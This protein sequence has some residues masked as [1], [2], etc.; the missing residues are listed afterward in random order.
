MISLTA[1]TFSSVWTDSVAKPE[2]PV[3]YGVSVDDFF[4]VIENHGVLVYR[5]KG[6]YTLCDPETGKRWTRSTATA[7][8]V[9]QG[10]CAPCNSFN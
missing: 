1:A 6:Q 7:Q 2:K 3:S 8:V 5:E 10:A 4:A 9:N